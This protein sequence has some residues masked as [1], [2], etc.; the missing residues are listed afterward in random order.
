M[1][2]G[3][4]GINSCLA[5]PGAHQAVGY[6]LPATWRAVTYRIAKDHAECRG[7]RIAREIPALV[8]NRPPESGT[9]EW[10]RA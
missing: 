6:R 9:D 5:A 2:L 1:L 10:L 4:V 3:T 8:E 7:Y